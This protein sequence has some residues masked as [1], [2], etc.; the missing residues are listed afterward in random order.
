MS[1]LYHTSGYITL[2][3]GLRIAFGKLSDYTTADKAKTI[4]YGVT[5]SSIK[6]IFLTGYSNISDTK[7]MGAYQVQ[8]YSMSN[9]VVFS[10]GYTYEL[11][12]LIIGY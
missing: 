2:P 11:F 7:W 8:S 4:S 5:F 3:D 10:V 6:S 1:L 9:M 12:W